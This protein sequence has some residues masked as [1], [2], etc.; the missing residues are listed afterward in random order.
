MLSNKWL[1]FLSIILLIYPF[2]WL[3]KRFHRKGGGVWEVCGGAYPLKEWVPIGVEEVIPAD[4]QN[5]QR[6]ESLPAYD[7]VETSWS[8]PT[9]TRGSWGLNPVAMTVSSSHVDNSH[10]RSAR[11]MQTTSGMKKLV[12]IKEG[13]W[14]GQWEGLIIRAVMGRYRSNEP[15]TSA[16]L[17]SPREL[18][19]YNE[20]ASRRMIV[21]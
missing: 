16:T 5:V 14:F 8:S 20:T 4:L 12:G 2:I 11:Y 1:K 21:V 17:M 6:E 7:S 9:L 19:G 3:F 10:P 18:D 13:E 15:L